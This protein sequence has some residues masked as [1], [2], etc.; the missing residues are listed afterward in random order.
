M[1][2]ERA[3]IAAELD[4]AGKVVSEARKVGDALAQA[5]KKGGTLKTS[6]LAD[7]PGW[8][9]FQAAGTTV[10]VSSHAYD[11]LLDVATG[12]GKDGYSV[13]DLKKAVFG[14]SVTPHNMGM[15]ERDTKYNDIGLICREML[16]WYD[17]TGGSSEYASKARSRY[18]GPY[19]GKV[20]YQNHLEMEK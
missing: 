2:E 19:T 6:M 5:K 11:K 17:K 10:A 7:P 9:L 14:C 12:P 18:S 20:W 16:A 8:G 3:V 4:G 15:N 13:E 1:A